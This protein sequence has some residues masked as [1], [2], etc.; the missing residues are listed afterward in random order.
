[1]PSEELSCTG[2]ADALGIQQLHCQDA[3][4]RRVIGKEAPRAGKLS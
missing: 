3:F 4:L 1:M 2:A